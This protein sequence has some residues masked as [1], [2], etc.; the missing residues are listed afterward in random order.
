MAAR[1]TKTKLPGDEDSTPIQVLAPDLAVYVTV[2]AVSARTAL[3]TAAEIVMLACENPCWITFGDNAVT[4]TASTSPAFLFPGGVMLV[5]VPDGA[6]HLAAIQNA[7]P[8]TLS[9][10]KMV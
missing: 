5:R 2:G 6:T 9:V 7:E 10:S 3:P 4:S 8:T 1:N